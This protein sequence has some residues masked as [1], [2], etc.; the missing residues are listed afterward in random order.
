M[1]KIISPF[2]LKRT[3]DLFINSHQKISAA[4][5][6]ASSA[7]EV[8]SQ[9]GYHG[10]SIRD[11]TRKAGVNLAA[12]HYYL[13]DKEALYCDTLL[14]CLNPINEERL[15]RL[16]HASQLSGDEPIP[17]PLILD[18]FARPF[19]ELCDAK[20]DKIHSLRLI[21]R[22][23]CE[24]LP[25][26]DQLLAKELHPVTMKFAHAIRRHVPTLSAQEFM[27]RLNFVVGSM[28]HT[29]ATIDRV[30][31]LTH[32]L[33]RNDDPNIVLQ[34]FVSF[35]VNTINAPATDH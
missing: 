33:C 3:F 13:G 30:K 9:Y 5:R 17:L 22:S 25:F 6:I 23:M 18:I 8:F 26:L 14:K 15:T 10:A 4:S 35:A 34:H 7:K 19:F 28:H 31:E 24:P 27:W 11:I 1:V 16:A 2:K 21:G 12:I 20:T 29:L 32:G